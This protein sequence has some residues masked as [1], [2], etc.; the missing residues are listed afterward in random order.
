MPTLLGIL[1][2]A[3]QMYP[4]SICVHTRK[5]NSERRE[6]T[7]AAAASSAAASSAAIV[8]AV[9]S[10]F[11]L[12]ELIEYYARIFCDFILLNETLCRAYKCQAIDSACVCE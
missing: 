4:Q 7:A 12:P 3:R 10:A 2:F 9:A 11:S 1:Q 6:L 8:V 5:R